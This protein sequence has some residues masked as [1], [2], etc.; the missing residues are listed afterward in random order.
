MI[1][2]RH[3]LILM[4]LAVLGALFTACSG[5]GSSSALSVQ[6]KTV[7]WAAPQFFADNNT[8]L[9]PS[10]DLQGFEIYIRQDPSF[11][12]ADSPVA[13]A[14]ALDNTYNLANVS[15][16]LSKGVTYYVSLRTVAVDGV[17]SDLC[18]PVSFSY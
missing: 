8:P 9:V 1:R 11:G 5:G 6:G 16:P 18:T 3:E 17:K 14:S 2:Q 13:T 7:Y 10:R 12:P 4:A 15:P